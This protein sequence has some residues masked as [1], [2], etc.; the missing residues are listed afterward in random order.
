VLSHILDAEIV[1]AGRYRW[2]LAQ[3]EPTLIGYD[4]DLG[5]PAYTRR[6]TIRRSC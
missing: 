1:S 5:W 3:E 6:T 2:I 4:Q